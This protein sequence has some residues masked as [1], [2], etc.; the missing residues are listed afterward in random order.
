[1]TRQ[2]TTKKLEFPIKGINEG[3]SYER[4]PAGTCADAL[5]MRSFDSV[6]GRM[7]GGVRAGV[8][9]Y[10]P[11]QPN[12]E[13]R[14]QDLNHAVLFRSEAP[15]QAS[16]SLRAIVPL[17]VSGGIIKRFD[18]NGY[19]AVVGAGSVGSEAL[20]PTAPV[21]FS[22][23]FY[24]DVFYVD[25][26]KAVYFDTDAQAGAGEVKTW[27]PDAGSLFPADGTNLP[28]L[29]CTWNGRIVLAGISSDPHNWFM[30]AMDSPTD[31]NYG[32]TPTETIAVAGN[33]G[34]AAKVADKINT[35]IPYTD[36][37]LLFGCDHSIWRMTGDPMSGGRLDLVSDVTGMAWGKPWCMGPSGEVYFFGS[38]G[39]LFRMLP[40]SMGQ[41]VAPERISALRIERRMKGL[42]LNTT[43][44]RLVWNDEEMGVNVFLNSL[45]GDSREHLF[46]DSRA[47][48]WWSD[49]FQNKDIAP[50][51]VHVLDGDDPADRAVLLGSEDGYVRHTVADSALDDEDNI[52]SYVVLGPIVDKAN[53]QFVINEIS[54]EF[55]EDSSDVNYAITTGITAGVA[56]TG[57]DA[58]LA[59]VLMCSGE[60]F[61]LTVEASVASGILE[62]PASYYKYPKARAYR[63][64]VKLSNTA[65][66]SLEWVMLEIDA[67]VS[68][69]KR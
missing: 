22:A 69:A 9:K 32:A 40:A 18:R 23:R 57:S 43:L 56:V 33:T 66:W 46:W 37:L 30:S 17:V 27:T 62:A 63:A 52:N 28:R 54:A 64:Y 34:G 12:G 45:T 6:S 48:A 4:Q 1:M 47:D 3:T 60:E 65:R 39:G 59:G 29:I 13:Q 31:F 50:V 51:A 21:I 67:I 42:N 20:S 2:R 16:L 68:K 10:A 19:T 7:S 53:R 38:R 41:G 49:R 8:Q 25:G 26:V 44:V 5:N 36:D 61:R 35:L 14:I 55:S 15:E 11:T 58:V 24:D